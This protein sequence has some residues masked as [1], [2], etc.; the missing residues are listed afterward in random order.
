MSEVVRC[1]ELPAQ[2]EKYS[3]A[4][5]REMLH[6]RRGLGREEVQRAIISRWA[7]EGEKWLRDRFQD[8]PDLEFHTSWSVNDLTITLRVFRNVKRNHPGGVQSHWPTLLFTETCKAEN[9]VS[10][11]MVTKILM[12]M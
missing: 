5:Q 4:T 9:F 11:L 3:L 2:W 1:E 6:G 12:V 7:D 8:Y 10:H